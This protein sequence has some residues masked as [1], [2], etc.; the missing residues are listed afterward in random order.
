MLLHYSPRPSPIGEPS[1]AFFDFRN[2]LRALG[3]N[4]YPSQS[5]NIAVTNGS[6]DGSD[7]SVF[8][9]YGYGSNIMTSFTPYILQNSY[10]EAYTN[11][12]NNNGLVLFRGLCLHRTLYKPAF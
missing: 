12:L 2:R 8:Q 9:N 10:I 5:R 4:G 1:P 6:I 3:N 11:K 7:R